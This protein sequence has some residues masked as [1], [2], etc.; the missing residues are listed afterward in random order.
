LN[1]RGLYPK[2]AGP[3]SKGPGNHYSVKQARHHNEP[4][5]V[6]EKG[7]KREKGREVQPQKGGGVRRRS[8]VRKNLHGKRSNPV[9]KRGTE[10]GAFV[11]GRPGKVKPPENKRHAHTIKMKGK[12]TWPGGRGG[13]RIFWEGGEIGTA[14]RQKIRKSNISTGPTKGMRGGGLFF[15]PVTRT[16][17]GGQKE[18]AGP[19][20][21]R[22]RHLASKKIG[23]GC[24]NRRLKG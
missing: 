13:G 2:R 22:A 21:D 23:S 12:E 4:L 19:T 8:A 11:R 17:G 24:C 1:S 5:H 6:E 14:S 9:Q 16:A 15:Q 3:R 18:E 20:R 7:D 10:K